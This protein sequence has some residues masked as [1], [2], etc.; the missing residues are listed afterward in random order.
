MKISW[1]SLIYLLERNQIHVYYKL[2]YRIKMDT[3][4]KK[5]IKNFMKILLL[6]KLQIIQVIY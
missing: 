2:E 5:Q 1:K 3:M 6:Q 4:K